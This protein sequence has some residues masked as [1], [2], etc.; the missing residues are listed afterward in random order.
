[1]VSPSAF[2]QT[3]GDS[4]RR[5]PDIGAGGS[6]CTSSHCLTISLAFEVDGAIGAAMP[7]RKLRPWALMI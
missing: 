4:R 7:H 3:G 6:W 2:H 5:Q 1:M